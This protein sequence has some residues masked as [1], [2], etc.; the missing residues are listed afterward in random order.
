VSDARGLH[1]AGG[2]FLEEVQAAAIAAT[3]HFLFALSIVPDC[4]PLTSF[5]SAAYSPAALYVCYDLLIP[6][7]KSGFRAGFWLASFQ[8]QFKMGLPADLRPVRGPMLSFP[9][10]PGSNIT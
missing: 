6:G 4:Q 7:R 5:T 3:Q 1:F 8:G 10:R 2:R 9:L